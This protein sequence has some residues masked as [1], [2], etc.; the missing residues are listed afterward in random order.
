M[1]KIMGEVTDSLFPLPVVLV[2]CSDRN[3]KKNLI[4][5]AWVSKACAEPPMICAAIRQ[6]RHSYSMIKDTGEFVVNVPT[7][8]IARELDLCGQVSGR[9]VDKFAAA[10]LTTESAKK[11][12][13]PL[14]RECPANF[15]CVVRSNLHLGT[16]DLFV[17]E[18]V[19]VH[20]D[21]AILTADGGVDYRKAKPVVYATPGYWTLGDHIGTY[22]YAIKK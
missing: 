22:G 14:V 6:N 1:A 10:E 20:Y 2:S 18:V 4:T 8:R 5:L 12:K 7:E 21:E 11:V 16:H 17:G 3:G 15:E 13:A 9:D 19:A